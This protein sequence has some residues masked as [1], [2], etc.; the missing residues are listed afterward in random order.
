MPALQGAHTA[1][2][3]APTTADA[4]AAGQRVHVLE[5]AEI[6]NDPAP[7]GTQRPP[8][9]NEPAKHEGHTVERPL[10]LDAVPEEHGVHEDAPAA[11]AYVPL[12]HAT[13]GSLGAAEL[14]AGQGEQTPLGFIS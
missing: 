4:V 3:L 8:E 10:E 14:P 9:E 2:E 12:A 11:P 7:Q 13:Q 1:P 6:E 5:P